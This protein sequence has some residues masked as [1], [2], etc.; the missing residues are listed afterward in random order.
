M[1]GVEGAPVGSWPGV[2]RCRTSLIHPV[3]ASEVETELQHL[4]VK[5]GRKEGESRGRQV[6]VDEVRGGVR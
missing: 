2:A 4:V 6:C 1:A 5:C 3:T